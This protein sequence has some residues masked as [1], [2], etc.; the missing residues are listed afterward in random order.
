VRSIVLFP[1]EEEF[2]SRG[3]HHDFAGKPKKV[4]IR[5]SIKKKGHCIFFLSNSFG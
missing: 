1:S 2:S 5:S 4:E 3:R